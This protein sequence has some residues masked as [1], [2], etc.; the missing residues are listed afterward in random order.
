MGTKRKT[1]APLTDKGDLYLPRDFRKDTDA[2]EKD[3]DSA[4]AL[5]QEAQARHEGRFA[6]TSPA[7]TGPQ[8][9]QVDRRYARTSPAGLDAAS[10]SPRAAP[11]DRVATVEDAMVEARRANRV[12]PRPNHWQQMFD[13][14]PGKQR[15]RPA[16][17][18]IGTAWNTTPP[19]SKRARLREHLEWAAEHGQL[20]PILAFVRSLPETEWL[21][22]DD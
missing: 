6:D 12:C 21:H 2:V 1:D 14:L 16:P 18:L 3:T 19:L 11:K 9:L 8:D 20:D 10:A 7:S 17:P 22:M 4:W 5:F 13:M 15:N